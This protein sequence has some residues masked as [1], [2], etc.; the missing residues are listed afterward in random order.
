MSTLNILSRAPPA[1]TYFGLW[2]KSTSSYTPESEFMEGYW[3]SLDEVLNG[4]SGLEVC[5]IQF[6]EE[7]W[8]EGFAEVVESRLPLSSARGVLR[9]ISY[10]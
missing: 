6:V 4:L 9:F 8:F 7:Q 3:E 2:I 1:L 5:E 10:C